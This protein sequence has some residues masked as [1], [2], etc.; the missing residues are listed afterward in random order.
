MARLR[1]GDESIAAIAASCGFSDL[2]NFNRAFRGA[3]GV[4]PR[5]YRS[6][7]RSLRSTES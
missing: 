3:L 4:A 5:A 2:A 1:S 7:F 6:R